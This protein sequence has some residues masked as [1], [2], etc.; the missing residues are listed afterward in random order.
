MHSS[1]VN[2]GGTY[3]VLSLGWGPQFY[4]EYEKL[5]VLNVYFPFIFQFT[6]ICCLQLNSDQEMRE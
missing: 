6:I 3:G 2:A 1:T 4:E 5:E